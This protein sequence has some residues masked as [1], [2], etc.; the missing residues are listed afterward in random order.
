M[1]NYLEKVRTRVE[2]K[3]NTAGT[4]TALYNIFTV[5]MKIILLLLCQYSCAFH[6]A[7]VWECVRAYKYVRVSGGSRI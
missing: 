1:L 2:Q 7:L 5:F 3:S 4:I 6:C